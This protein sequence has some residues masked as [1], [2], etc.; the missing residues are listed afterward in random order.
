M[1]EQVVK[2]KNRRKFMILGL[3]FIMVATVAGSFAFWNAGIG[4]AD[5]EDDL[6]LRIGTGNVLETELN[7][8]GD[9]DQGILIPLQIPAAELAVDETHTL[10]YE[11]AVAWDASLAELM[12]DLD[13]VDGTLTISA[14]ALTNSGDVNLLNAI[15]RDD[16]DLFEITITPNSTVISGNSTVNVT[17]SVQMNL[18]A[19]QAQYNQVAG[20]ELTLVLE[21]IVSPNV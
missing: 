11:L 14:T 21:F 6:T 9:R 16:R 17:V 5:L 1:E 8:S 10:T 12:A 7:L 18:P 3:A 13:N 19:D 15:G 2:K 20:Q 4:A